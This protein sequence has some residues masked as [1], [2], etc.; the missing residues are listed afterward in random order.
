MA[1]YPKLSTH[2]VGVE[3]A[4]PVVWPVLKMIADED[5]DMA[6]VAHNCT[7]NE[8]GESQTQKRYV[9]IN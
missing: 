8:S 9:F 4:R 2:S 3:T 7:Q 1:G 6:Q 5:V